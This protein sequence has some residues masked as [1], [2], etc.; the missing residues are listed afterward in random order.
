MNEGCSKALRLVRLI[1]IALDC[2]IVQQHVSS[3]RLAC[4]VSA[5][6]FAAK[7]R[8]PRRYANTAV[9]VQ[10]HN[11]EEDRADNRTK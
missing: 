1:S 10:G 2:L 3:N 9:C 11:D 7:L 6:H 8:A 4:R 5:V